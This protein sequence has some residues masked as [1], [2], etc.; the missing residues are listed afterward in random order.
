MGANYKFVYATWTFHSW[1]SRGCCHLSLA[2]L[3]ITV[4]NTS[5]I[6]LASF[7]GS[8]GLRRGGPWPH[9]QDREQATIAVLSEGFN[10][11]P[12]L[13][14]E[15]FVSNNRTRTTSTWSSAPPVEVGSEGCSVPVRMVFSGAQ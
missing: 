3:R 15:Y 8:V 5:S 10:A 12:V 11:L 6:L 7:L 9:W 2:R 14:R 1:Y 4:C 13:E